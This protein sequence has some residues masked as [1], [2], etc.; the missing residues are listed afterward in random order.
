MIS[1]ILRRSISWFSCVSDPCCDSTGLL[2]LLLATLK[3]AKADIVANSM[4]V[5]HGEIERKTA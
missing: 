5:R 1:K 4:R 3:S 2:W